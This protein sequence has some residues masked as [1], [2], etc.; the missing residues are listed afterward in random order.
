MARS[1]QVKCRSMTFRIVEPDAEQAL[2][3]MLYHNIILSR[4]QGIYATDSTHR[5]ARYSLRN[6]KSLE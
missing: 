4:K 2:W 5:T 3:Y 6:K 1:Y